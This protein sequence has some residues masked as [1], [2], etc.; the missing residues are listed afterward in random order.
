MNLR[1]VI[2]SG[3]KPFSRMGAEKQK[4]HI[5]A[6]QYI[7]LLATQTSTKMEPW[8]LLDVFG[9]GKGNEI[10][11]DKKEINK[12][13]F[14]KLEEIKSKT[15]AEAF[16]L[17]QRISTQI[18]ELSREFSNREVNQLKKSRDNAI[19]AAVSAFDR[20]QSLLA[21]ARRYEQQLMSYE[22]RE[23]TIAGQI[24]QI[25]QES[26]WE[27]HQLYGENVD[28]I[29]KSDVIL[30]HKNSAAGVDLRVNMGKFAARLNLKTMNLLVYTFEGNLNL[31]GFYHPHIYTNGSI[32]WG[33]ASSTAALKLPKGEVADIFRLLASVLVN[34]NDGNPYR[35]LAEF[36]KI[37]EK[38][39]PPKDA[40]APLPPEMEAGRRASAPRVEIVADRPTTAGTPV[41]TVQA[42]ATPHES[43]EDRILQILRAS[44]EPETS[45][46]SH[47]SASVSMVTD[48]FNTLAT[49]LNINVD[50]F[51][52]SLNADRRDS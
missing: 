47:V 44:S 18:D 46:I 21:D 15:P 35:S 24:S 34:Y 7:E 10:V 48:I 23:S 17:E 40:P 16:A 28:L 29:T 11:T 31:G 41:W 20:A 27:F 26:F 36:Q 6:V 50:D 13:F 39:A 42:T 52:S 43:E 5:L 49:P 2:R 33:N 3:Y 45:P 30:T 4:A 38:D 9:I 22:R 37:A 14:E 19:N 25:A 8:N 32:C 1:E 12:K 51:I